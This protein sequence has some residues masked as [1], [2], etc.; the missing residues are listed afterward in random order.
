MFDWATIISC[1]Y[2]IDSASKVGHLELEVE[3]ES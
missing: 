2:A 1:S 3:L